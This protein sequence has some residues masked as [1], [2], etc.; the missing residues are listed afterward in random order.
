MNAYANRRFAHKQSGYIKFRLQINI[1]KSPQPWLHCARGAGGVSR[2]RDCR[3]TCLHQISVTNN[4]PKNPQF[5]RPCVK[6]GGFSLEK[7]EG[8]ILIQQPNLRPNIVY[9]QNVFQSLS[10]LTLTALFT[11]ESLFCGL[12]GLM[13]YRGKKFK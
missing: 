11:K 8:L 2:L 7:P 10:Q 3:T 13:I 6:G 4:S 12:F 5:C 1:P 9:K